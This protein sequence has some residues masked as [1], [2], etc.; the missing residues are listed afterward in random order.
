MSYCRP[1][2]ESDL[3]VVPHCEGYI[4]CYVCRLLSRK[5]RSLKDCCP[6]FRK[7]TRVIKHLLAHR[8]A[9]HKVP[10]YAIKLLEEEIE[11]EGDTV[12]KHV[13]TKEQDAATLRLLREIFGD[14]PV[15]PLTKVSATELRK[16]GR[17]L[18]VAITQLFLPHLK[19]TK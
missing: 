8:K 6:R 13:P 2:E 10:D 18:S 5:A 14:P 3:Y 4:T 15:R 11:R 12:K 17:K 7:R 9:G 16:A 1:H 19:K